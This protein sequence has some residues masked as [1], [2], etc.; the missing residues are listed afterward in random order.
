MSLAWAVSWEKTKVYWISSA[1]WRSISKVI[2]RVGAGQRN[3]W[4]KSSTNLW[5]PKFL[6]AHAPP[7][8]AIVVDILNND[9]V[10]I[11]EPE[12]QYLIWTLTSNRPSVILTSSTFWR[13]KEFLISM[14]IHRHN[15]LISWI[16][17]LKTKRWKENMTSSGLLYSGWY[18]S[19]LQFRNQSDRV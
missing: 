5:L 17:R 10:A 13:V 6:T 18:V 2:Y 16:E 4:A 1:C 12:L 7:T 19:R 15:G 3:I 9:K 11:S 8:N 14:Y